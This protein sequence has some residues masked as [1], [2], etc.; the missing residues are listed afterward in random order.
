MLIHS[1][2]FDNSH[3]L[4]PLT[5][6]NEYLEIVKLKSS[7]SESYILGHLSYLRYLLL[8]VGVRRHAFT[9]SSHELLDQF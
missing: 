3:K 1:A 6:Y 4:F 5:K 2:Y 9:S 8:W 7:D